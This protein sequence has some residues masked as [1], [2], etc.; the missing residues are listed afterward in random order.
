MV[1]KL[2]NLKDLIGSINSQK[3][4]GFRKKSGLL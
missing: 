2:R 3:T 1:T 4:K